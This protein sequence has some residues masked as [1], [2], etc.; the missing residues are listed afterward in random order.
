MILIMTSYISRTKSRN[1]VIPRNHC[2]KFDWIWHAG[3]RLED[4]QRFSVHFHSFAIITPWR[5]VTPYVWTNLK[6]LHPN[7]FCIT[8]DWI[9]PADSGEH[10]FLHFQCIF[11][12][13][14]I[15]SLRERLLP[16]FEQ[17]L[18]PFAQEWFVPSQLKICPVV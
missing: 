8:F 15:S 7:I 18:V 11:T 3:F 1:D 5:R 10:F 2:L 4:F 16:S 6:I 9:W 14:L 12:I 13:L 17:T